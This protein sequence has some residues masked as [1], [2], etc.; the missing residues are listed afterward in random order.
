MSVE[1]RTGAGLAEEAAL[2]LRT[3]DAPFA[4]W[5]L[6]WSVVS[7]LSFGILNAIIPTPFF[8]RPIA[9]EPFAIATWLVTAP[10]MGFVLATYTSPAKPI[11]AA[12]PLSM[13]VGPEPR[14]RST[15]GWAGGLASFL[16]IG[17]PVCNKIALVLLGTSG[18]LELYG[19][20]QPLIGVASIALLLVTVVWRLRMRARAGCAVVPVGVAR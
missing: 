2:G 10:L 15:L 3:L 9:A 5:T 11:L 18:A 13:Q 7:L 14:D 17:C 12:V 16:A 19:P 1:R 4:A 6:A 20:I 8:F